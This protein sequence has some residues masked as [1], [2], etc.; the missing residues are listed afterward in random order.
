MGIFNETLYEA[1]DGLKLVYKNGF[2]AL[3]FEGFMVECLI[4]QDLNYIINLIC[5]L[6]LIWFVKQFPFINW[7][8]CHFQ[9]QLPLLSL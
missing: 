7:Y 8:S 4:Y 5:S 1:T 3:C 2:M 9:I 6:K